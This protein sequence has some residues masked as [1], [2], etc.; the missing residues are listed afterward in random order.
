MSF[1]LVD[2][3]TQFESG[4][5]VEGLKHILASDQYL[6]RSQSSDHNVYIS[7]LVGE[8]VGQLAAWSVMHAL[9]FTKRPVAGI[10]SK[11]NIF[12]E[13]KVGETLSINSLAISPTLSTMQP[14]IR[15]HIGAIM[16]GI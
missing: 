12:D 14:H 7:S 15:I 1:I 9:D 8:A 13:V 10:V 5:K 3:I 4:K 16:Y 11:V 2:R 6:T